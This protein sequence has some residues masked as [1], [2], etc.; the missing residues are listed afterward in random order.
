MKSHAHGPLRI[1]SF[2][3]VMEPASRPHHQHLPQVRLV[4]AFVTTHSME[5][6]VTHSVNLVR[7]LIPLKC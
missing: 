4:F 3:V 1:I 7:A 2:A 6:S 5:L